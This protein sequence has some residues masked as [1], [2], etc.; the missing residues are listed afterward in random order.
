MQ[1]WAWFFLTEPDILS[2]FRWVAKKKQPSFTDEYT[3]LGFHD[4]FDEDEGLYVDVQR[5]FD[6]KKFSLTLADL[7]NVNENSKNAQLLDDHSVWFA[8]FR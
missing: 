8:N 7:E 6:K 1:G 3:L 4:D 5:I 2:R